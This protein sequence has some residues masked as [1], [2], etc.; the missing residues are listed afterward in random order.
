[1]I[2]GSLLTRTQIFMVSSLNHHISLLKLHVHSA[3]LEYIT[4]GKLPE[5]EPS[6]PNWCSPKL[7][8]TQWFN[9]FSV[10]DRAEAMR[11]LWG[12]MSY[13][14]RAKDVYQED[15]AMGGS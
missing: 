12:V 4:H 8:R 11:G 3:Y 7:E 15:T 5:S 10:E 6:D 1:V 2:G 9:L 13:L 14:L